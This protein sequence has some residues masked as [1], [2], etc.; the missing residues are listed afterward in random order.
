MSRFLSFLDW[1]YRTQGRLLTGGPAIERKL[2][3]DV[4]LEAMTVDRIPPWNVGWLQRRLAYRAVRM[5]ARG[6]WRD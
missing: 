2:A 3:D 1:L 5:F 6:P 4:F